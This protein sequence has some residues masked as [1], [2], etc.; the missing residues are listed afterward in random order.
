MMKKI[1]FPI[2]MI[3]L[4][5]LIP[6]SVQ[7][8]AL[9]K[10]VKDSY[11]AAEEIQFITQQNIASGYDD[12]TFRPN[13]EVTR[14]QTAK[15]LS[16]A[17]DLNTANVTNPNF[18]DV[19]RNYPF[20]PYIAAVAAEGIMNGDGETFRP[21]EELSRAEMA[22]VLSRAFHFKGDS[23]VSFSDVSEGYWAYPAIRRLVENGITSGYSD[24]RFGPGDST[25]RAHF[26]VF[27]ARCL[28]ND[29]RVKEVNTPPSGVD[30][31]EKAWDVR[32]IEIDD[33][34]EK[35]TDSLGK[36]NAVEDSRYGFKW[37]IY[38]DHFDNYVQYGIEDGK[39]AAIYS[40]QDTWRGESGIRLDKT[41]Q[42]V[43][44]VYGE[45]LPSIQKGGASFSTE[46][47][48]AGTYQLG[49]Q[50][51]TFFYDQHR[52]NRVTAVLFI[53]STVEEQFRQF[54]AKPTKSLKESYERQVFYL[55]N[56]QRKRYG[57]KTLKWDELVAGTARSHSADMA[58]NH[59]FEHTNLNG[60]DPFDRMAR[61]G[62][63]FYNAAENIAY[64]QVSPIYAHQSWMN[65]KSHRQA[66]LGDY[67]RIGVGVAF[68][69]F[70]KQPY[71][72][73][74]FYTPR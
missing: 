74:N 50:Y 59:Y 2:I 58:G 43:K 26:S 35:V 21:G 44:R 40:N 34:V 64:G 1:R 54:Y 28:N 25:T 10:D 66:L 12:Q 71:Y 72:T 20:Y 22:A 19:T 51:T 60:K 8:E 52:D 16:L 18:N 73:Q 4:F 45:P 61:D 6:L 9:F 15:M 53:K 55:T 42:D 30:S 29:F 17:L 48:S 37:H 27:L 31:E 5:S 65:S 63:K 7:G 32:G 46:T 67:T 57:K 38:H 33:S 13:D 11:W 69:E 41:K 56:A 3:L 36:P 39:V 70:R 49:D 68:N 24:G 14:G 62:V 47:D 23:D